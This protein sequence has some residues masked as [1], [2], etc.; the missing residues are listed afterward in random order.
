MLHLIASS[1]VSFLAQFKHEVAIT[2]MVTAFLTAV[3]A[4]FR[5]A[6]AK[7]E[8]LNAKLNDV[9]TELSMQRNNCL[10]TLQSQGTKQI[11]LL[12]KA[13]DVLDGVRLDNRE[14]L[15]HL[16]SKI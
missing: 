15:T 2:L 4:P 1:S 7:W 8:A 13:V 9:H 16:R 10:A 11:E 6:K 3:S 12:E 14:V 5:Q